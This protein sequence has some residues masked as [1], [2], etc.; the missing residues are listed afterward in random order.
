M[1]KEG[2]KGDRR[3]GDSRN[4]KEGNMTE[5][6]FDEGMNEEWRGQHSDEQCRWT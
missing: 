5:E 6:G 1:N 2:I 3:G 4:K